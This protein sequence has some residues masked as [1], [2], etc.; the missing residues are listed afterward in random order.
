MF[1]S[2][3]KALGGTLKIYCEPRE[4]PSLYY[5]PLRASMADIENH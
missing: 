5:G 4:F 3:I 2:G 1:Y